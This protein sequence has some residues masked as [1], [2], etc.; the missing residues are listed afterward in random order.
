[1]ALNG[2]R[3]KDAEHSHRTHR[4]IPEH[5][6]KFDETLKA[7]YWSHVARNMKAGDK[8]E[9]LW[10]DNSLYAEYLVLSIQEGGVGAKVANLSKTALVSFDDGVFVES[11]DKYKIEFGGNFHK[12]RIIRVS[13]G[14][15]IGKDRKFN[16]ELEARNY[17]HEHRKAMQTNAVAAA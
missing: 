8:I 15:V 12:F 10:E 16:T 9:A 17:L 1:L 11:G 5:T 2:S 4:V 7:V 3:R 14:E 6:D 13:D